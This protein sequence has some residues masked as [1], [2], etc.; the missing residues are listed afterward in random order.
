VFNTTP[1]MPNIEDQESEY[2]VLYLFRRHL[3][4][5]GGPGMF[6]GGR[7]GE[8]AYTIYDAPEGR[9][10]GLFAGTGAEMP[11]ALGLA[12]GMPG[13]AISIARV[14]ETDIGAR[15][16][17]GKPLPDRLTDISARLE[18][19]SCKHTRS[20]I[21]AGDVWYHS[22][23]GGGG[24]GDPL[25]RTPARVADDVARGAVSAEAARDIYGVILTADSV[26]DEAAT[27]AR[28]NAIRKDR[29]AAA[30]ILHP[31]DAF[32]SF[33]GK[34]AIEFGRALSVDPEADSVSCPQCGH[35][36]C[37]V[38]DNLLAHL[39][40]VRVPLRAAGAVR[41]EAYDRGRFSLR[42]LICRGC[43]GLV[44]VQVALDGAPLSFAR[45][46]CD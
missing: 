39:G 30:E 35:R 17:A 11:N 16:R 37:G 7:S 10:E 46:H 19:L 5:S 25:L 40:L 28:R 24:F 42:Q 31:G 38:L 12:G 15:L 23:Q 4:D 13:S 33:A 18:W 8:L 43:G 6:R 26:A 2:P 3:R 29:L 9:L 1:N 32:V 22:W 45:P 34:K 41:G 20:P 14:V 21:L 44:D 36:H 27:V